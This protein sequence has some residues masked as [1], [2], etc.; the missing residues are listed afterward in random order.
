M[1]GESIIK[2]LENALD[3]I[4]STR[5]TSIKTKIAAFDGSKNDPIYLD[6]S[7]K[8]LR[9]LQI[10]YHQKVEALIG[11]MSD[12][13]VDE[14]VLRIS[15]F[16]DVCDNTIVRIKRIKLNLEPKKQPP[17]PNRAGPSAQICLPDIPLP[18]F[19]GNVSEWVYFREKFTALIIEN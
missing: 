10:E 9:E 5:L 11:L 3:R 2:R 16:D 7:L 15:K 1:P 19:N 13:L 12:D 6:E 4:L 17:D 8:T 14:R 18:L